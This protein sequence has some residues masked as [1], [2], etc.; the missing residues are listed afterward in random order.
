LLTLLNEAIDIAKTMK[1]NSFHLSDKL[2]NN[3]IEEMKIDN[4][5][6]KL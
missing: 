4:E 5:N 3:F 6:K 2:L 1:N